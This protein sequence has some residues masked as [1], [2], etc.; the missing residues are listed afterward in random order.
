M[1]GENFENQNDGQIKPLEFL[2]SFASGVCEFCLLRL[3]YIHKCCT[4][5]TLY[6]L[7]EVLRLSG[8]CQWLKTID[9][10]F[11][12][13]FCDACCLASVKKIE[14]LLLGFSSA[15]GVVMDVNI[16]LL[17]FPS[18]NYTSVLLLCFFSKQ[19]N[20]EGTNEP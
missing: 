18:E 19:T 8:K 11:L 10:L 9:S 2:F 12:S 5:T 15:I 6:K 13:S 7:R 3:H 4:L 20:S 14:L 16:Q 1:Y 17:P